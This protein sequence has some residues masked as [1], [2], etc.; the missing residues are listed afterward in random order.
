MPNNG[1]KGVAIRVLK[2]INCR[3]LPFYALF[4]IFGAE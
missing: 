1:C 2:K 3:G 4:R